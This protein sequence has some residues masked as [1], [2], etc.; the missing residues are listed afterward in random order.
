MV[1]LSN[2]EYDISAICS[3]TYGV[4]QTYEDAKIGIEKAIED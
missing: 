1:K 4:L 2:I 3:Y